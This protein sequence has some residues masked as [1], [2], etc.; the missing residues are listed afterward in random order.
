MLAMIFAQ[1]MGGFLG[2]GLGRM[3]RTHLDPDVHDNDSY[4]PAYVAAIPPVQFDTLDEEGISP[5]IL[6]AELFGSFFYILVF[7]SLK[8][9]TH[10]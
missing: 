9:R 4:F 6:F 5:E 10:L 3:V 8:Y 7:L 1:I 2:I